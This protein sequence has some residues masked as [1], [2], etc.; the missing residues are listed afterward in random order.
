GRSAYEPPGWPEGQTQQR[1]DISQDLG[2]NPIQPSSPSAAAPQYFQ[3][4]D[5]RGHPENPTSRSALRRSRKAHNDVLATVGVC[6]NV[7]KNGRLVSA[8]DT[9]LTCAERKVL[10]SIAVENEVGFWLGASTAI[11]ACFAAFPQGLR[12]RL[13]VD[14]VLCVLIVANQLQTYRQYSSMSMV[15]ICCSEW[16]RFGPAKYLFAGLPGYFLFQVLDG[17]RSIAVEAIHD[18]VLERFVSPMRS[19]QRRLS[20]KRILGWIAQM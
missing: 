6:V 5:V 13:Q 3:Q 1:A 4:Y 16:K 7:D 10:Y 17:C 14:H 9:T 20:A 19:K 12:Q 15:E 18:T 11:F 8:T 2:S